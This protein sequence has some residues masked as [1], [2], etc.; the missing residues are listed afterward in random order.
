M[1]SMFQTSAVSSLD[2]WICSRLYSTVVECERA[3]EAYELHAVTSALYSFWVH[4]LCDVYVVRS[5]TCS[6][7]YSLLT[8]RLKYTS[9]HQACPHH[10]A[11]H[12]RNIDFLPKMKTSML[13]YIPANVHNF[14]SK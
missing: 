14:A 6:L 9:L 3:L 8:F 5:S 11:S 12:R 4:S 2:R 7:L 10:S 1:I 13:C